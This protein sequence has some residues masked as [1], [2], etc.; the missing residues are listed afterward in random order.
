[1]AQA[2]P[3]LDTFQHTPRASEL[4]LHVPVEEQRAELQELGAL[5][6]LGENVGDHLVGGEV[7]QSCFSCVDPILHP[8]VSNVDVAGAI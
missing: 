6:G 8:E 2:V 3:D 7:L 5:Q 4:R 1:M